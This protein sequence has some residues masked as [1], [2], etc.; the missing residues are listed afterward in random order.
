MSLINVKEYFKK[1]N[2]ENRILE[3]KESTATVKQAAEALGT[4]EDR[5]AKS[6]SFKLKDESTIMI[7]LSGQTRIDNHKYKELFHE[8]AKMLTYEEVEEKI[9]HK[10]GGVCPFAIKDNVTVYLDKSLKKYETVFPACGSP[11][12]AIELSIEELE[13]YSNYKEWIDVGEEH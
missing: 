5:I 2:I 1:Y 7:V 4:I 13:K 9:G 6:M 3:F 10:V 12:S 8:K 11:N